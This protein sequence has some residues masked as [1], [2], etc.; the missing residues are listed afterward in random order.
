MKS[1]KPK[2]IVFIIYFVSVIFA[3]HLTYSQ[4]TNKPYDFPFQPESENWKT[5]KSVDELYVK[6]QIPSRVLNSLTTEALAITCLNYPLLGVIDAHNSQQA[7]FNFLKGKFNGFDSL[8]RRKDVVNVL[9]RLYRKANPVEFQNSWTTQQQL[10]YLCS[11]QCLEIL[12]AQDE[13]LG[14]MN[15]GQ[16]KELFNESM[17]KFEAKKSQSSIYG[18]IGLERSVWASAKMMKKTN[19]LK[20][21]KQIDEY[22][23]SGTQVSETDLS[24]LVKELNKV[25]K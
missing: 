5:L 11:M 17:T 3:S 25:L 6:S 8:L 22:L 23:E 1:F 7:G 10:R 19:R 21:T 16:M 20:N 4:A 2:E 14:R 24:F 15:D 18:K 9:L 13:V 12:L